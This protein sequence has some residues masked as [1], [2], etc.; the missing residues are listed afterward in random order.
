M[1]KPRVYERIERELCDSRDSECFD[2]AAHSFLI[3]RGRWGE[4][5]LLDQWFG[6]AHEDHEDHPDPEDQAHAWAEVDTCLGLLS[7]RVRLI[8][9]LVTTAKRS[10]RDIAELVG[11]SQPSISYV[12]GITTTWLQTVCR[13]RLEFSDC[14]ELPDHL[15]PEIREIWRLVVWHH[16]P[17]TAVAHSLHWSQGRARARL[18]SVVR[19]L[20]RHRE[21][22]SHV[23]LVPGRASHK[24]RW[25]AP[26][27][28][29]ARQ[30]P[31]SRIQM[32]IPRTDSVRSVG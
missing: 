9:W 16:L 10:Q 8:Y 19:A 26:A 2:D 28:L 14:R 20:P 21:L 6:S 18:L 15:E 11:V 31:S 12:T 30:Q 5:E 27:E 23:M 32:C 25:G 22:L 7:E 13:I 1:K 24:V 29:P 17:V 3:V 4:D